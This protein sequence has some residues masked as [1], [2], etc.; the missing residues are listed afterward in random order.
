MQSP[1]TTRP[2]VVEL[3]EPQRCGTQYRNMRYF[4]VYFPNVS[5]SSRFSHILKRNEFCF[6]VIWQPIQNLQSLCHLR[7]G[8]E[9]IHSLFIGRSGNFEL[10]KMVCLRSLTARKKRFTFDDWTPWDNCKA[11]LCDDDYQKQL[12]RWKKKYI[13]SVL[14][15]KNIN[16]QLPRRKLFC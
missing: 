10:V 4:M 1:R 12:S 15:I 8:G 13:V 11:T 3:C 9:G 7:W 2:L 6:F 16:H 14:S 5:G